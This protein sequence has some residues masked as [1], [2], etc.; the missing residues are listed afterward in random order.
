MIKALDEIVWA[1]NPKNDALPNLVNYL[2]L[3]AQHFLKPTA[4]RCRLDVSPNLP[5]LSLNA[6]QRHTL[7]L[8]TKEAL[9]N[10]AKHSGASELWLRVTQKSSRLTLVIEDNGRGFDPATLKQNGNGSRNGFKNIEARMKHLGGCGVVRGALGQGTRVEL[11][12]P[13]R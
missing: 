10:A 11:D 4:I 9:A 6:E 5:D 12:L 8:L 13:L 7:F 3:F 2:C 1:V